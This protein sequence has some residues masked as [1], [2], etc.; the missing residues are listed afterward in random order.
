MTLTGIVNPPLT[1]YQ[2]GKQISWCKM[3]HNP[4]LGVAEQFYT[5][6]GV[7]ID[8]DKTWDYENRYTVEKVPA[9]HEHYIERNART[10]KLHFDREPRFYAWLGFDKASGSTLKCLTT[11]RHTRYTANTEKPPVPA[12]QTSALPAISPKN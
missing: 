1:A 12:C 10:A 9:G 8:E 3:M 4:T 2:Q 7:P 11:N 5:K 6:N